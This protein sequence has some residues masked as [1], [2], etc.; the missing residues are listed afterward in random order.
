MPLAARFFKSLFILLLLNA[1][2]K[3]VWIF[4]ID[5]KVQLLTGNEYG[6]Y[7]SLLHLSFIP[8]VI[9]DAGILAF[10]SRSVAAN[11]ADAP[12]RFRH[13]LRI[14]ILLSALYM[15]TVLLLSFLSGVQETGMILLLALL[16]VTGSFY[17]FFRSH[18]SALQMFTAD[19]FFSVADKLLVI[20]VAGSILYF[21]G[22]PVQLD[23][24]LFILLQ[25]A[26]FAISGT[27]ALLF[28]AP[29]IKLKSK[30]PF[31]FSS[32]KNELKKALPYAL[33]VLLMTILYR[34][35]AFLLYKLH[36]NGQQEVSKY[37]LG[38]RLLDALN[39]VGFLMAS[40]LLPLLSRGG[41]KKY[42]L[43]V[44]KNCSGLLLAFSTVAAGFC[45]FNREMV[46]DF[47]YGSFHSDA[48][49]TIA[50]SV[51][52]IVG[53]S[54]VHVYGT[55]LTA[56]GKVKSLAI[57]AGI[58]AALNIMGNLMV[59]PHYGALGVAALSA[60]GQLL[61][62]ISLIMICHYHKM[63]VC[64]M[65]YWV[66]AMMVP[67]SIF[68][69]FFLARELHPPYQLVLAAL[70]AAVASLGLGVI[71]VRMMKSML[72]PTKNN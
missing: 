18:I 2:V 32:L 12:V 36:P 1:V 14:K 13:F 16:Q 34:F 15:F 52:A 10:Y 64:G 54:L 56:A 23:T 63:M 4:F 59:I 46:S 61:F 25:V 66:A 26:A 62:G 11:P 50:T 37:A 28:L 31:R 58:F 24:E 51:L 43:G 9:A 70:V 17:L 44:V 22:M 38:F 55:A 8:A 65:R 69:F 60:S 6:I 45:W 72:F 20:M 40:F 42:L 71:N 19:A 35:D 5:R 7:F 48:A 53:C 39:M 27:V 3:P 33:V 67:A 49:C 41:D 47:L 29:Y 68:I 57:G 30:A 21:P